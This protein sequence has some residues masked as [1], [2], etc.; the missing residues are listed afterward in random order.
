[1]HTFS[2]FPGPLSKKE[3]LQYNA[4]Q[5][6]YVGDTVYDLFVRGALVRGGKKNVNQLHKEASAIVNCAAQ[7]RALQAIDGLL[8]QDEKDLV[9]R[10]RNAHSRPPKNADPADYAR[11]TGLEALIGCLYLSGEGE[12]LNEIMRLILE[13]GPSNAQG[14]L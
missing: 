6:A 9:R 7:S 14:S 12:R 8:S 11:A 4:L 13:G 10:G 2:L 1:L 5:L 3:A